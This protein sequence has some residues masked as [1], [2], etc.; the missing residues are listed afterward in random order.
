MAW[1]NERMAG[2]FREMAELLELSGDDRF[3]ARAYDRAARALSGHGADLAT[4][5]DKELAAIPG[6]GRSMAAKVREYLERGSVGALEELR[7]KVPEGLRVL[8]GVPGV[9]PRKARLIHDRLGV[10]TVDDLAEAVAAGRIAGL[11]GMGARTEEN[12]RQAMARM[13]TGVPGIP[14][15][16]ALPIAES[17]RDQ[18]AEVAGV[19]RVEVAGSLRRMK[20]VVHDMD[21]LAAGDEPGEITRAFTRLGGVAEVAAVG[22]TRASVRTGK[23]YQVD[24]RVVRPEAWGA[25][26]Q[27]FTGAKEHNVKVRELAVKQGLKLSE[28]G[29]HTREGEL[30]VAEDEEVVYDRLGLAWVPPVLR[31]DRGE[32]E[33]ARA[34]EL[35]ELVALEDVRGDLHCHTDMS[36]DGTAPLGA[37]VDAARARGYRFLA[38]TDHAERLSFS[39]A[40]REDFLRQRRRLRELERRRGDIE[41]LHGVEL[42][43]GVDGSLDYDDEFLEGFDVLV[44]SVHDRLD[45]SR[46]EL[47]ARLLRACEHPAVNVVGHPTG[48]LLGRR[49]AC[50]VDLEALC[51]TAA[52]TGT[53]LEVNGSPDRLDLGD[54][55]LRVASRHGARL[56]FGSDSH[57]PGHLANM[58]LAVATAG[59]GWVTSEQVV[60]TLPKRELRRFLAKGRRR[61]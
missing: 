5:S 12:L 11:P 42:N 60:N 46:Q 41:L 33:A 19:R 53:A 1:V 48:R 39:A 7:A 43:I 37:M 2:V 27:Y 16:A 44:A 52:R 61:R 26:L 25:A 28:Y 21:L 35:P 51:A 29:L 15:A 55:E 13:A 24:L 47:T 59:R 40:T 10:S 14:L 38:I 4:L 23:G 17:L 32:V 9:G 50:D 54:E 20:P 36:P 30:V 22:D 57:G 56:A 45:Q 18:L 3:R 58:R 34:G 8:V 6:V 49:P 31:E